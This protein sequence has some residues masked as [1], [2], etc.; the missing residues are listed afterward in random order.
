MSSAS[1]GVDPVRPSEATSGTA[2]VRVVALV[3]AAGRSRRFGSGDKRTARLGDGRT[4]LASVVER[5]TEVFHDCHVV[6]REDDDAEALGLSPD[7]RLIRASHADRGLG[8]SLADAVAVLEGMPGPEAVALL[9]G[10]MPEIAPATLVALGR[11]A[12]RDGILCPVYGN[13]RGHPVLFGR[14]LWPEL[15]ALQGESG[16]REV[17]RRHAARLRLIHVEDPGI[18]RDVDTPRDLAPG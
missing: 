12:S 3:M 2:P 15:A 13:R 14:S 8:S 1:S 18:H 10:D 11:A 9:L 6:L 7:T 17:V 5:A 4:L 16:A